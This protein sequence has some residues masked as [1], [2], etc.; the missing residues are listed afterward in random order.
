MIKHRKSSITYFF[1][2]LTTFEARLLCYYHAPT[3]FI[4]CERTSVHISYQV[5]WQLGKNL[6]LCREW[7]SRM[8]NIIKSV[9]KDVQVYSRL[10]R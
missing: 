3:V 8:E 7:N 2:I 4:R 6:K 9:M 1:Y 10:Y 5:G